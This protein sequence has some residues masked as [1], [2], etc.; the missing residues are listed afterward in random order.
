MIV[1][2]AIVQ[3]ILGELS[4]AVK[5]RDVDRTV[6]MFEDDAVLAGTAVTSVGAPAI[7]AY[8]EVIASH[9]ARL[10]W[11][12]DLD[13]LV[14]GRDGST[15]WFLAPCEAVFDPDDSAHPQER[16]PMRMS[17]VLRE[18]PDGTWRWSQFHGS[19]AAA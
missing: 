15:I 11:T 16:T 12:W 9:P 5:A 2:E 14:A 1:M 19:I 6:A 3:R 7:R 10:S 17:G 18:G 4:E 8:L 13:A